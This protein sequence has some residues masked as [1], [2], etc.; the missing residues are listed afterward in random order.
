MLAELLTWWTRQMADLARPALRRFSVE[1]PDGLLIE[2]DP[3]QPDGAGSL[4]MLRRRRGRL[5][6]LGRI[7]GQETSAAAAAAL[8]GRDEA[9][10]V[11]LT[12]PPLVRELTLPLA[13]EAALD[14]VLRY[15]MDRL[16]PFNPED[17]CYAP[18]AL[19]HDRARGLLRLRLVLVPRIWI[20]PLLARMAAAGLSPAF[21][22]VPAPEG[23]VIRLPVVAKAAQRAGRLRSARR[24]AG[25]AACALA[26]AAVALPVVRQSLALAELQRR[27][28]DLRPEVEQVEALRKRISATEAGASQTA[29]AHQRAGDALSALGVLTRALPDDT[30]LAT[31]TMHQRRLVLEGHSAAATRLIN[32]MSA[33]PH[34]RNP[35]FTGPVLRGNDGVENF[36]L[37]VEYEP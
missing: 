6:P 21:L 18:H 24:L 35:A 37:Q 7:G 16:T 23:G 22:E 14:R 30:W 26:C 19:A 17:V 29:Q 36:T 8:R 11:K 27:M 28:D 1:G 3:A 25:I 4:S 2:P 15:E 9:V 10:I 31:V 20:A 13:A 12:R 34:L 5:T 32:A 33:D